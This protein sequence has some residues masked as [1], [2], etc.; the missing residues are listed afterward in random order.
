MFRIFSHLQQHPS[1]GIFYFRIAIPAHLRDTLGKLEIKKTLGTGLKSEAIIRA[2]R[3]FLETQN[4]FQRM[5][6]K[7][8]APAPK[9]PKPAI[10]ADVLASLENIPLS[11]DGSIRKCEPLYSQVRECEAYVVRR[12]FDGT[13]TVELHWDGDTK[14]RILFVKGEP[15]AADVPQAM[16]F[17]HDERGWRVSINNDE[18]FDIPEALVSGG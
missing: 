13:A 18:H 6:K 3:L 4:L 8:M 15:K 1:S 12:G 16:T 9:Q 17:T 7:R 11:S 14:R 10:A 2:Q 5:E